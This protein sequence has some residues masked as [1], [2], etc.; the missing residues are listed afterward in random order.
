MFINLVLFPSSA[1]L[2]DKDSDL[3]IFLKEGD[4]NKQGSTNVDW[5]DYTIEMDEFHDSVIA[6][7]SD[8]VLDKSRKG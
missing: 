7:E 5:G 1:P 6:N 4:R 3:P 2:D 8:D